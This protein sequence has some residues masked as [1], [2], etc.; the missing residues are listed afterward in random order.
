MSTS[1][2]S[3]FSETTNGGEQPEESENRTSRFKAAASRVFQDGTAAAQRWGRQSRV[4]AVNAKDRIKD[5]PVPFVAISFVVGL[6][7]GALIGRL[8]GRQCQ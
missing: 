8:S 5:D 6:T 1:E 2:E 4:V 3:G 7:L